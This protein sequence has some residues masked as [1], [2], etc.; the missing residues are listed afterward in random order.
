[1]KSYYKGD[2]LADIDGD[3]LKLVHLSNNSKMVPGTRPSKVGNICTSE[4]KVVSIIT[5]H[6]A[7]S[8]KVLVPRLIRGLTEHG[9]C[10]RS[11]RASYFA[12]P[13]D[14][15]EVRLKHAGT[16]S[17]KKAMVFESVIQ[18]AKMVLGQQYV[19]TDHLVSLQIPTNVLA[20][21]GRRKPTSASYA[22]TIDSVE[23]VKTSSAPE[24]GEDLPLE[25]LG[26]AQSI[27]YSGLLSK[28]TVPQMEG[29]KMTGSFD[30]SS[31]KSY[32]I[33]AWANLRFVAAC[34]QQMGV[35]L[36]SVATAGGCG[37]ELQE[38]L[39]VQAQQRKVTGQQVELYMIL[40]QVIKFM[41]MRK[42]H[43]SPFKPADN[44]SKESGDAHIQDIQPVIEPLKARPVTG[45]MPFPCG[46]T[47]SSAASPIEHNITSRCITLINHAEPYPLR[48]KWLKGMP[49]RP[50]ITRRFKT[51]HS[52]SGPRSNRRQRSRKTRRA[53]SKACTD[54]V[55]RSL[56][57]APSY[58]V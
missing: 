31:N 16:N 35:T 4:A 46:T 32:L 13:G 48:W 17:G 29:R 56:H 30:L 42:Y 52:D 39:K 19:C 41:P 38:S 18:R 25:E 40:N 43:A 6:N 37:H 49:S 12:L 2:F 36:S 47:P 15:L 54:S 24:K 10:G 1:M 50:S 51:T 34:A 14:G 23:K 8:V 28:Y 26:S 53:S 21:S 44:I 58:S 20:S 55:V 22:H 57:K 33:K 5:N 11:S 3:L 45:N 9:R 7:E 27:G